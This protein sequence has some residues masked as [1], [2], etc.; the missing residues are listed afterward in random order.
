[1]EKTLVLV[2]LFEV[3]VALAVGTGQGLCG[4]IQVFQ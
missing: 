3:G 1:M 2:D 4:R